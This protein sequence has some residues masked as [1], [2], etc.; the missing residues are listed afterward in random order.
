MLKRERITLENEKEQFKELMEKEK[1]VF[2][3]EVSEK[4]K[5]FY[6]RER[7]LR[8][9]EDKLLKLAEQNSEEV[10]RLVRA[11]FDSLIR[12]KKR[13]MGEAR[14]A[15]EKLE[16]CKDREADTKNKTEKNKTFFERE[17]SLRKNEDK[18]LRR[19]VRI[20]SEKLEL[21]KK[22]EA[23]AKLFQKENEIL[24]VRET[25]QQRKEDKFRNENKIFSNG[26]KDKTASLFTRRE[27]KSKREEKN[28]VPETTGKRET[29]ARKS[30]K[31]EK[32]G[33][34]KSTDDHEWVLERVLF[35][36]ALPWKA[37]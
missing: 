14:F 9:D 35:L 24:A 31:K 11:N 1:V 5:T 29:T 27:V 13:E 25:N 3:V 6:E 8:K 34:E 33:E 23:H 30:S 18:L 16:I 17:Q 19:E 37:R 28:V 2:R 32:K 10:S 22:Q 7:N 4:N 36:V 26:N 20:A 21:S 12:E 15:S